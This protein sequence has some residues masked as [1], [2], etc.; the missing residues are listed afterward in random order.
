MKVTRI[1]ITALA[2]IAIVVAVLLVINLALPSSEVP[3]ANTKLDNAGYLRGTRLFL[4][5]AKASYGLHNGQACF[6]INATVRN[7]YTVQQP[8]P[9]DNWL[10]PSDGTAWFGLTATLYDRNGQVNASNVDP[11]VP[12]GVPEVGL[13][14]GETATFVI[15]MATS[16]QSISTYSIL[17]VD[18]AGYPIP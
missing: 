8:P 10:S 1:V 9:M 2:V 18:I 3:A 14:S 16:S 4:V 15:N 17:L 13:D 7:D 12:L 11:G 6:M 5:S